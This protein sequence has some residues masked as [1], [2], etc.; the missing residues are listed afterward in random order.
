MEIFLT[1][2][3][4]PYLREKK[5]GEEALLTNI[6]P[7]HRLRKNNLKLKKTIF[8]YQATVKIKIIIFFRVSEFDLFSVDSGKQV[9]S[10]RK[11]AV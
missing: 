10:F 5:S 3:I 7:M 2:K 1:T 8:K 4:K 9:G 11:D 6:P